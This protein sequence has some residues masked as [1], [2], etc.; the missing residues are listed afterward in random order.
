MNTIEHNL[1]SGRVARNRQERTV[2]VI[3]PDTGVMSGAGDPEAAP[4]APGRF[5][6]VG[7][8]STARSAP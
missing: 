6:S 7:G 4:A 1:T 2:I 5:L 8:E 3:D